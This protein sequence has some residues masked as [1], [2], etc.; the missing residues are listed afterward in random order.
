MDA[1]REKSAEDQ[2]TPGN[3][4]QLDR[5]RSE[6]K[7]DPRP[8]TNP[9]AKTA[10]TAPATPAT[11]TAAPTK[12]PSKA[13]L[14][15]PVLLIGVLGAGGWYGYNWWTNGRFMVTTDDAYI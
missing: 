8:T 6:S 9:E 11:V 10:P 15:V 4:V 5:P 1:L 7:A 2:A 14:I 13:R 3:I 12:K